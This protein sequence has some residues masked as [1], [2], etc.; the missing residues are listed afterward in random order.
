M[1]EAVIDGQD[2]ARKQGLVQKLDGDKGPKVFSL[3]TTTKKVSVK[4]AVETDEKEAEVILSQ[5]PD[6][7]SEDSPKVNKKAKAKEKL[8]KKQK[9]KKKLQRAAKSALAKFTKAEL[10]EKQKS[11][12][13]RSKR[14]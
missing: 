7:Q 6:V 13:L 4:S 11:L 5:E 1:S 9:L 3:N 10:E 14:F 2:S 8:L 12:E